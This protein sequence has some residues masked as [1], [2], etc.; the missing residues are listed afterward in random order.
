V[1]EEGVYRWLPEK[2]NLKHLLKHPERFPGEENKE[3]TGIYRS[4]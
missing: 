4:S 1:Y 3:E 2:Q